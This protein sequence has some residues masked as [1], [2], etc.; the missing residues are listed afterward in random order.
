MSL[1]DLF[2]LATV[3]R[4]DILFSLSPLLFELSQPDIQRSQRQEVAIGLQAGHVA[5]NLAL[6]V[7]SVLQVSMYQPFRLTIPQATSRAYRFVLRS[8][9]SNFDQR[10]S[11]WL[12][13][14]HRRR[15]FPYPVQSG[16]PQHCAVWPCG[17]TDAREYRKAERTGRPA[18]DG[19]RR[20]SIFQ[21]KQRARG[22]GSEAVA[23]VSARA[24]P[25]RS[26]SAERSSSKFS[27]PRAGEALRGQPP[28]QRPLHT[29][30]HP[31][32]L[33]QSAPAAGSRFRVPERCFVGAGAST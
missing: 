16:E 31:N 18:A 5:L 14:R 30:C 10:F 1:D 6:S 3:A 25:P 17:A 15:L 20:R 33:P 4:L 26:S 28:R 21:Q 13:H 29:L 8:S 9:T 12:P 23:P 19:R 27:F 22:T 2:P 32:R 24:S 11:T 7:M